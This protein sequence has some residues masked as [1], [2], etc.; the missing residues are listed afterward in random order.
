MQNSPDAANFAA[1]AVAVL[2]RIQEDVIEC[3]S[4]VESL[5]ALGPKK[6]VFTRIRGSNWS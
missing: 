1:R 5:A 2:S 3:L 4:V 6:R